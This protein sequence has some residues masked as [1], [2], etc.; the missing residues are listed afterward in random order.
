MY[1]NI[2]NNKMTYFSEK[3]SC[4]S[5]TSTL[6]SATTRTI[7]AKTDFGVPKFSLDIDQCMAFFSSKIGNE[8][9]NGCILQIRSGFKNSFTCEMY[10]HRPISIKICKNG[11]F[12]FTGCITIINA[13]EC[14]TYILEIIQEMYNKKFIYTIMI[15]EVMTNFLLDLGIQMD[16]SILLSFINSQPNF[17]AFQ[18]PKSVAVNCKYLLNSEIVTNRETHI[19]DKNGFIKHGIFG[20]LKSE[21]DYY[22]TFR[23]FES[24]KVIISGMSEEI[25]RKCTMEFLNM[26]NIFFA[27][28][29]CLA[30]IDNEKKDVKKRI[31]YERLS[32]VKIS[33]NQYI[34]IRGQRHYISS[35]IK[36]L[37]EK[38]PMLS[39][40][41]EDTCNALE[42]IKRLKNKLKH[43]P[44]FACK[45]VNI[46]TNNQEK[47]IDLIK[48]SNF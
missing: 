46:H 6:T 40:V 28:T 26:M 22:I 8:R 12:Q 43:E 32:L 14:I 27:Q 45:N 16:N 36:T 33:E 37:Q 3:I 30:R 23:I 7:V 21:K 13:Y 25:L 5:D 34:L 24:G 20:S 41:F 15:Y 42:A 1:G 48:T 11:S 18:L 39:I 10:L 38:F 31:H 4:K 35:R 47:L 9:Q 2:H 19:F 29:N 44:E 17:I